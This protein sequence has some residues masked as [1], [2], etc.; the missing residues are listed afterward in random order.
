MRLRS[1]ASSCAARLAAEAGLRR[2][3]READATVRKSI[4]DLEGQFDKSEDDIKALQSVGQIVG[5]VLRMLDDERCA[6]ER[7][8]SLRLV[9]T[10][11]TRSVFVHALT[12]AVIVKASSGPRYVVGCRAAVD[13]TKLKPGTRVSLDMTTLTVMRYVSLMPPPSVHCA[14]H[15]VLDHSSRIC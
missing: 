14:S 3:S 11:A 4:K 15:R 8:V 5:E 12:R 10:A 2:T 1:S 6:S 7:L 13:K 9:A